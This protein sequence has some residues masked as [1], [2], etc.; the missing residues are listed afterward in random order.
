MWWLPLVVE[1]IR[2]ARASAPLKLDTVQRVP[3]GLAGSSEAR[4]P[5]PH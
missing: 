4:A 1:V 5:R 2:G 3:F